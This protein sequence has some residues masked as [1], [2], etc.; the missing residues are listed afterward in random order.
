MTLGGRCSVVALRP[1]VPGA[2]IYFSAPGY[3]PIPAKKF[4]KSRLLLYGRDLR[5]KIIPISA[6][7]RSREAWGGRRING[8]EVIG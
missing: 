6:E 3:R 4:N 2:R 5:C 8:T 7:G 1:T